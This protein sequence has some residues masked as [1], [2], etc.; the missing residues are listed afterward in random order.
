MTKSE[1][2]DELSK[3]VESCKD[4]DKQTAIIKVLG[5]YWGLKARGIEDDAEEDDRK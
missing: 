5:T 3:V 2:W 1:A 4:E